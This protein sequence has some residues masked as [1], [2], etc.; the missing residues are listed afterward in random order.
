MVEQFYEKHIK[1]ETVID[2]GISEGKFVKGTLYFDK[3]I[4]NKWD[5]YVKV[6][7]IEQAV[8]VRGLKHLNRA[9]HLDSV[10]VRLCNWVGWEKAQHKLTKNIDFTE[11]AP[12]DPYQNH[13]SPPQE[14][15]DAVTESS[16]QIKEDRDDTTQD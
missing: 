7:K 12:D 2:K 10:V 6:D 8:K 11:Q 15:G 14:D 16:S 3:T 13:P 4:S 5:A 9:L 1:D